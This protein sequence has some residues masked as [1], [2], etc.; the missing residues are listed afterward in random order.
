MPDDYAKS[1]G[2]TTSAATFLSRQFPSD[3]Y[4]LILMSAVYVDNGGMI[5][6]SLGRPN[7]S[8]LPLVER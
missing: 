6:Y 2:E 3:K 1:G 8:S 5:T 4:K 7:F